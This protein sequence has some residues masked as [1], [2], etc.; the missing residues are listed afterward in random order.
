MNATRACRTVLMLALLV[1]PG[2]SASGQPAAETSFEESDAFIINPDC[3][4]VAYD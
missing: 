2:R 3:G 4:W 1:L